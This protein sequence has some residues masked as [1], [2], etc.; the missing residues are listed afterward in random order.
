M[1][2]RILTVCTEC[3]NPAATLTWCETTDD[4]ELRILWRCPA[5]KSDFETVE[6]SAEASG[7]VKE[8]IEVFWPTLLVA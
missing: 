4:H 1:T 5:C 2:T 7:K 6:S 3:S 8:A